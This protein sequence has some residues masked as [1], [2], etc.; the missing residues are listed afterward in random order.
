MDRLIAGAVPGNVA[1]PAGYDVATNPY[2]AS[3][4]PHDHRPADPLQSGD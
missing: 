3:Q 4:D 2:Q 1:E